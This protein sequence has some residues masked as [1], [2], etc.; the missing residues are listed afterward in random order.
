MLPFGPMRVM[1]ISDLHGAV[2][3]LDAVARDCD[4]LLVLGDLINVLDY[5]TMDGILVEVFGR[6]PVAEAAELRSQGRF[7]EA[8]AAIR[9][10][11]GDR[12]EARARF[13]ELAR[14]DYRRVF[15]AL[16]QHTYVTFGNVDIP[17]LLQ[18]TKPDHIRFVDAESVQ[19]GGMT[20][21]FVGGGVRT[22]L[23]VPGEVPDEEYEG[24]FHRVGPVDVICTHMP[25]RLP[26]Y[27]YDV[28]AKKFEPGSVA[29]IGYVQRHQPRFALFGHVH[30]PLVN[31]GNIG[32]TELVNVGHFR[33]SG[34]GFT[35]DT[36][37]RER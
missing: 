36:S 13:L 32:M 26:W 10:R 22:P 1:A 6:E 30:Q 17:E 9:S 5:R 27:T 2:E 25:P 37:D 16:P 3:H 20:F 19:L 29:L 31:R 14:R 21:G 24:K 8:R 4:A 35:I 11:I 33:G 34:R 15:E 12:E 28:V 23:A 18:R 7:D